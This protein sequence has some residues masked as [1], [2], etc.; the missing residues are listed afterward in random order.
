M[1]NQDFF[2]VMLRV[3]PLNDYELSSQHQICVKINEPCPNSIIFASTDPKAFNFD[4]IADERA[5]QQD[6]FDMVGKPMVES[7]LEGY[8]CCI[9]AYGQTG[10][11]KTYTMQGRGL[12]VI[13]Q[14][15]GL[16]P[17]ILD[18]IFTLI[19]RDMQEDPGVEY[20]MTC[21]YL[22]IYNE[23][24]MDLVSF[25]SLFYFMRTSCTFLPY[26]KGN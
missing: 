26:L 9:F 16:Q 15:C 14:H 3:R 21:N 18:Y 5:T 20:L 7:C 2:K 6:I 24:I 17:R 25:L 19:E 13:N 11:G 10:T 8:N 1:S 23:Q 4:W 22:E 12:D